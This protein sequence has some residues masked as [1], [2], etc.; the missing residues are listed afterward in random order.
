MDNATP[1]HT[2]WLASYP[3]SGNT[4]FRIFLANLLYPEQSPVS[5]NKMPLSTPIASARTGVEQIIGTSSGFLTNEETE[6][7]R[8]AADQQLATSWKKPLLLR[9]VH[10]AY[11]QLPDGTPLLGQG[12]E[13][14]ALYILRHP[15]D[16]AVSAA[17]HWNLNNEEAAKRLLNVKEKNQPTKK[18]LKS[19]FP[20]KMLSW[21]AHAVSWLRAPINRHLMRYE[22]MQQAPLET[23]RKAVRFLGLEHDDA[24]IKAALSAC[25]FDKLQA[26]EQDQRFRETPEKTQSFFRGGRIGDGRTMLSS[27]SMDLLEQ[28]YEQVETVIEELGL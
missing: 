28:A 25:A 24:A 13:Y 4:W 5:I 8:V 3:K 22:D 12:P 19:Q 16:V 26:Q 27:E 10:D 23:F 14:S 20:Q 17:N 18:G 2:V 7:L 9:K 11:T 6:P 1:Q 21:Q 15:W